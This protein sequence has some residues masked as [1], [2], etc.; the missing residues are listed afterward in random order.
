MNKWQIIC[1]VVALLIAGL[2]FAIIRSKDHR[3]YFISRM[4]YSIGRDL[5]KATNSAHLVRIEPDLEAGLAEL[6]SSTSRVS[7]VLLGDEPSPS[8]NGTA[9]CRLVLTNVAGKA[10]LIRLRLTEEPGIFQVLGH[11]TLSE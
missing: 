8:Q 11:R 4:S 6:L 5:I 7:S 9:S 2:A 3:N 1:P 10:L